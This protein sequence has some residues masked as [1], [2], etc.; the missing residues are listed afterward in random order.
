MLLRTE[1]TPATHLHSLTTEVALPQT[2]DIAPLTSPLPTPPA[3]TQ[4]PPPDTDTRLAAPADLPELP[5][6]DRDELTVSPRGGWARTRD[7]RVQLTFPDGVVDQVLDL[8]VSLDTVQKREAGAGY[9]RWLTLDVAA[10]DATRATDGHVRLRQPVTLTFDLSDFPGWLEPYVVHET[11][12]VRGGW[13]ILPSSYDVDTQILTTQTD[14]FSEVGVSGANKFP[15]D[16]SHYLMT[17][18]G[19]VSVFTGAATYSYDFHLPPGRNGLAPSAS[20]AYN[21]GSLNA[22]MGVVQSSYVGSGWSLGGTTAV[23]REIKT[24]APGENDSWS[25]KWRYTNDFTL[26]L[27]G[28]GYQLFGPEELASDAGCRYYAEDAPQLRI[29]RY[30]DPGDSGEFCGFG[31]YASNQPTNVSKDFWVVTEPDGTT[32]RLGF[33]TDSEQIVIMN[34]YASSVCSDLTSYCY[35]GVWSGSYCDFPAYAG[36]GEHLVPYRW[37][38]D[39]TEDVYGNGIFYDYLEQ[40][41]MYR[42]GQDIYWDQA[43]YPDWIRY[44]GDASQSANGPHLVDFLYENRKNANDGGSG[45][46]WHDN[47]EAA[48]GW[49]IHDDYRLDRVRVCS[50]V[51]GASCPDS[52]SS[53]AEWDLDYAFVEEPYPGLEWIINTIP[54]ET[55]RLVSVTKLGWNASGTKQALP[56]TTFTYESYDQANND[57]DPVGGYYGNKLRYPRLTEVHNGFGGEVEYDYN[58]GNQLEYR[59]VYSYRVDERRIKDGMGNTGK[60]TYSYTDPCYDGYND[61]PNCRRDVDNEP[62]YA[63][64]GHGTTTVTAYDYDN[65]VLSKQKQYFNTGTTLLQGK[66]TCTKVYEGDEL[67]HQVDNVWATT[68]IAVG[69]SLTEFAYVWYEY[70][71]T[72]SGDTSET[73]SRIYAFDTSRQDGGQYGQLTSVKERDATDATLRETVYKYDANTTKWVIVPR[74]EATFDGA[75]WL[76]ATT[77]YLY[78]DNTD[79]N[80]QTIGIGQLTRVRA[81]D[82]PGNENHPTS[83]PAVD[84]LYG[85]DDYGSVVT[86]TTY[87]GYGSAGKT[88]TDWNAAG[89]PGG[90]SAARV[91]TTTYD[92]SYHQYPVETC[93]AVGTADELCTETEYYGV[94]ETATSGDYG[95]FGQVQRRIDVNAEAM[96]YVYDAF[97][98]QERVKYPDD[99]GLGDGSV[100]ERYEYATWGTPGQQKIIARQGRD[101]T[102]QEQFF[103]GL[104]RTIQVHQT[105]DNGQEIRTI[106]GYDAM[107]RAV[108]QWTPIYGP[109]GVSGNPYG[110]W[111][112]VPASSSLPKTVTT[113][114][115]LG[116]AVM[117]ESPDGATTT[118]VSGSRVHVAE[119]ANGHVKLSHSDALGRMTGVD[120]TLVAWS[121]DFG[122]GTLTSW[123]TEGTA[124]EMDGTAVITGTT[125]WYNWIYRNALGQPGDGQGV[126]VSFKYA[127]GNVLSTIMLDAGS[128]P[129]TTY[130]RWGLRIDSSNIELEEYVGSTSSTTTSL[131]PLTTGV[132][133]RALLKVDEDGG[134]TVAVWERDNPA[135]RSVWQKTD[136]DYASTNWKFVT[137]VHTGVAYY[138]DYSE[139]TSHTTTYTYD[140]LDNLTVVTDTLGNATT[141]TYD[142]LGRKVG[143]TDPDMGQWHYTYDALGNLLTQV[144]ARTQ[145][146]NYYYTA[147]NE[148]RG[149]TYST[150]STPSTY[151]RAADP[152][153]G[154]YTI[155]YAYDESGHGKGEGRR[156]SMEDASGSTAWTYD[157]RGR[158]TE[159]V[160][161]IDTVTYTTT[162]TYNSLDQVVTTTYPDGEVVTHTYNAASQPVSV[163][164]SV[165]TYISDVVYNAPGQ[166]DAVTAGNNV[167]TL[168][169]YN[170]ASQR[171]VGLQVD[172]ELSYSYA[173]DPVGN[174]LRMDEQQAVAYTETFDTKDA[175]AWTY[176]SYQTVVDTDADGSVLKNAGTGTNFSANYYR[177]SYN[178]TDGESLQVRFKT[179]HS[180]SDAHL[181]IESDDGTYRRF[182]VRANSGKLFAQY[183]D[184]GGWTYPQDLITDFRAGEWYVIRIT[185]GTTGFTVE[186]YQEN[187]ATNYGSYTRSMATGKNW[188]FRHWVYRGNSYLD[189]YMEWSEGTQWGAFEYDALDRLTSAEVTGAGAGTYSRSYTYDAIG[190]LTEKSD[191]G[192]YTYTETMS[193][194]GCTTGT[195]T[196]KPHAV[197]GAGGW[198]YAYDCNGNMTDRDADGGA[199]TL[200]YN[201]EN[202]LATAWVGSEVITYT[203]DGDGVLAMKEDAGGVTRYVG[204]H[205]E[206]WD[207]SAVPPTPYNYGVACIDTAQGSGYIMYSQE[208]VH[209]RFS[210]NAPNGSNADH[211]ICVKYDNGWTYDNNLA[212]YAF[213][214]ELTDV[215]VAA[216]NF[217]SDSVTMLSGTDTYEHGIAKGYESGSLGFTA[218]VWAGSSN[219]GEFGV[220]GSQFTPNDMVVKAYYLGGQ[221]V[222]TSRNDTL[223]YLHGDH[224]G[225]ASLTTDDSGGV[226]SQMRYRPYGE[227]RS[228]SVA[229][230]RRFT[231]QRA[232][233]GLGLQD[234]RARYYDSALG[235][236]IQADTIVPDPSNPQALNRCSYAYGNP[237]RYVDPNGHAPVTP[238]DVVDVLFWALSAREF[239]NDPSAMNAFWWAL[240]TVSVVPLVPSVGWAKYGN[241]IAGSY[242]ELVE[243]AARYGDEAAQFVSIAHKKGAITLVEK[244][245]HK[246]DDVRKGALFELEFALKNSDEIVEI[247]RR[248]PG[249]SEIDFVTTGNVFVNAKDYNWASNFYN[250]DFGLQSVID[251]FLHQTDLYLG[252]GASEVKFVFKDG[253][254]LAVREALEAAGVIV[255]VL[256]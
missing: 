38:V 156:T 209:T 171:L 27:G 69:V 240:D 110:T 231:G 233:V 223:F 106:T 173:Y 185:L 176:N 157:D 154:N 25:T 56:S 59:D 166:L 66:P 20:L 31:P 213:D 2:G 197:D 67:V 153:A 134:A 14:T 34:H 80:D 47:A 198:T 6:S 128:W 161:V 125:S 94:N 129:G 142:G 183:N 164:S 210:D 178:L 172:D 174:V 71:T 131:L 255:E 87:A 123:N 90:G 203:Y 192:V 256:Q 93:V 32:H 115:A 211:F 140:T 96:H 109:H 143:M 108:E 235:R 214:P 24:R 234:F 5:L 114:D 245:L 126:L 36:E 179:D 222:A 100:T 144:D 10:T 60:T 146:T 230:D 163:T 84:T 253:V 168:Y 181:S 57:G 217:T 159:E 35:N 68:G 1:S 88:G 193:V 102:W 212:Y 149:K 13:E 127:P 9:V 199:D 177:G 206:E 62:S 74:F 158:V 152:G 54:H 37:S 39:L 16:G 138:D 7:G 219:A 139:L 191:V 42:D 237:L 180:D 52:G 97:G 121:D 215:L 11:D 167:E 170:G 249:G 91:V 207:P 130:R 150:A 136:T 145:A 205:Y 12:E 26:V 238:W 251:D 17:N 165:D 33:T 239:V 43:Q 229:T 188:R 75:G 216:V 221:R 105:T 187:D 112:Y 50:G 81:V 55:T 103:D 190:N 133:Y 4:V 101:A 113:Y 64:I 162:M 175:S 200:T 73:T 236:F 107:G 44:T 118:S 46:E 184:G 15:D 30:T 21:S 70:D 48:R 220:T 160:K 53:T 254:P 120:E 77:H 204:D 241:R 186:A 19:D 224:L 202:K 51:S 72:H 155:E 28:T 104:G 85:Y 63:L 252:Y 8:R 22:V 29:M 82:M 228:G 169:R 98:R 95:L 194:S 148:L 141:M 45:T 124:T 78:D 247:G 99:T 208:S 119:D 40:T 246:V 86:T 225:S 76:K 65:T 61:W 3:Q 232:E 79:V 23:V 58:N 132:W 189:D 227:T 92:S 218:N 18:V 248:L 151:T 116:Q 244:L 111:G 117:V 83:V 182:G 135:V 195:P 196:T 49:S 137:Q 243:F 242:D 41:A 250:T 201:A 89:T 147:R 122:D 226:I